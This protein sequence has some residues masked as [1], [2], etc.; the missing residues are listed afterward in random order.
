MIL[1]LTKILKINH[2]KNNDYN[3]NEDIAINIMIIII[4]FEI[5]LLTKSATT[6]NIVFC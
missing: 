2:Y 5:S 3:N 6:S 1:I 4:Y